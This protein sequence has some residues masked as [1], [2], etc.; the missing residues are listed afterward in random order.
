MRHFAFALARNMFLRCFAALKVNA[1]YE[2]KL[3]FSLEIINTIKKF[4]KISD[5]YLEIE[6]IARE[7]YS[8][9]K[10]SKLNTVI[11]IQVSLLF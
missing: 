4:K 8:K 3:Y 2:R 7:V 11:I 1:K 10:G 9:Q 5:T 6:N